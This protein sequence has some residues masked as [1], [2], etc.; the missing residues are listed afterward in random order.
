VS[1]GRIKIKVIFPESLKEAFGGATLHRELESGFQRR[2][3]TLLY[4]VAVSEI[5]SGKILSAERHEID[6]DLLMLIPPFRGHAILD[7][8]DITDEHDFVK[9]DGHMKI[10]D[11]E[12]GY[13]VGDIVAFS[14]PKLAHMAVRQADVAATNIA[15]EIEGRVP[16]AEYY[17]EIAAVIDAGGSDS[18]YL[19]Y[20]IWDDEMYRLKKGSLWGWAKDVHDKAWR[21]RHN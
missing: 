14:G 19:H 2:G 21:A 1:D 12:N 13:A 3:I 8:L 11:L 15:A 10:R 16:T 7:D 9:V 6:Y 5:T 20:G 4:E 18:I 17:H